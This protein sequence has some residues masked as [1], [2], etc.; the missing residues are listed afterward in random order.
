MP[1]RH[2]QLRR[3]GGNG[4]GNSSARRPGARRG[5]DQAN[6]DASGR[7]TRSPSTSRPTTTSRTAWCVGEMSPAGAAKRVGRTG[8]RSLAST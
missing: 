8:A 4:I 1:L 5:R 3:Q 7:S 2:R 6:R